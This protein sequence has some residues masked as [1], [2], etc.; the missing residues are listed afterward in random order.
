MVSEGIHIIDAANQRLVKA[1]SQASSAEKSVELAK[2]TLEHL[3]TQLQKSRDEV[4]DAEKALA[5]AEKRWGVINVDDSDDEGDGDD[6]AAQMNKRRKVSLSPSSGGTT[7]NAISLPS[8]LLA[9][10]GG[11]NSSSS[12]SQPASNAAP[13]ACRNDTAAEQIL[14]GT[15]AVNSSLACT[16]GNNGPLVSR[17]DANA[18]HDEST[19]V[20][21]DAGTVA[22]NGVYKRETTHGHAGAPLFVQQ[23]TAPGEEASAIFRSF[24]GYW[25]IVSNNPMGHNGC[26]KFFYRTKTADHVELPP[27]N[28]SLWMVSSHAVGVVLPT[29]RF[30]YATHNSATFNASSTDVQSRNNSSTHATSNST[31]SNAS[32]TVGVV[33]VSRQ[34]VSLDTQIAPTRVL[35]RNEVEVKGAGASEVNGVYTFMPDRKYVD[36][37]VYSKR[38]TWKGRN[39]EF[40]LFWK[41]DFVG[42]GYLYIG[43]GEPNTYPQTRLYRTANKV[44][45]HLVDYKYIASFDWMPINDTAS[46]APILLS[47]SSE[48]V[49][50]C[51]RRTEAQLVFVEGCGIAEINGS[52]KIDCQKRSGVASYTKFGSRGIYRKFC[53]WRQSFVGETTWYISDPESD[54]DDQQPTQYYLVDDYD[55]S[56]LPPRVG[57]EVVGSGKL[58]VPKLKI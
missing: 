20:V 23:D 22:V 56:D 43:V 37:A 40:L 44:G 5:T 14:Q 6:A 53:L 25:F 27:M 32:S 26:R 11:N 18:E 31:A 17:E 46:P 29:F 2:A 42:V 16:T 9:H 1:K 33:N 39:V 4:K 51:T 52:Y 58:P 57:W 13:S 3:Q 55:H 41:W 35:S 54:N 50:T 10:D 19:I 28:S 24:G 15:T 8:P 30:G 47:N 38:G 45:K 21:L 7:N 49:D 12:R 34:S 48:N 36:V